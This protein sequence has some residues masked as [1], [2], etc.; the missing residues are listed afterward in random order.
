MIT[1]G[2]SIK[3]L[4]LIGKNS[5]LISL[6]NYKY[7][8]EIY[9]LLPE[10]I[11]TFFLRIFVIFFPST[12]LLYTSIEEIYLSL[13]FSKWDFF[14]IFIRGFLLINLVIKPRSFGFVFSW[15]SNQVLIFTSMI[16]NL[17][18][19]IQGFFLEGLILKKKVKGLLLF[20]ISN[21][22]DRFGY[23]YLK[24]PLVFFNKRMS[25]FFFISFLFLFIVLLL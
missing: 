3:T 17:I 20:E 14:I 9:H 18:K 5:T 12:Y 13:P 21:K 25:S 23:Y 2:Y 16:K 1:I 8:E 6:S 22:E 11:P 7:K 19:F 10:V 24:H 15:R 4:I